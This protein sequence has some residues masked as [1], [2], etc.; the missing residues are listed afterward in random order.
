MPTVLISEKLQESLDDDE[1][2]LELQGSG[3]P[4]GM[5]YTVMGEAVT[6]DNSADTSKSRK[7]LAV[8]TESLVGTVII[9]TSDDVAPIIETSDDV[10]PNYTSMT[11]EQIEQHVLDTH[12]V[13]LVTSQKKA[14]MI[15]EAEALDA[16][17]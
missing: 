6:W 4:A 11:K 2:E 10:A 5:P 7:M 17:S 13:N 1:M 8:E 9:E 3:K 15:K 16:S 14:D 12:D